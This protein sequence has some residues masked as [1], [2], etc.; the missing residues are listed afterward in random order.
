[1][2][3]A[4]VSPRYVQ[5]PSTFWIGCSDGFGGELGADELVAKTGGGARSATGDA[6]VGTDVRSDGSG[7]TGASRALS[8][9]KLASAC[10]RRASVAALLALVDGMMAYLPIMASASRS[11]WWQ[12]ASRSAKIAA[13]PWKYATLSFA[14]SFS[15]QSLVNSSATFRQCPIES[16]VRSRP[17]WANSAWQRICIDSTSRFPIQQRLI[18]FLR[19]LYHLVVHRLEGLLHFFNGAPHRSDAMK[20]RVDLVFLFYHPAVE[21]VIQQCDVVLSVARTV[22]DAM[23]DV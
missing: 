9:F 1:M 8:R 16:S 12:A 13:A 23:V 11:A 15:T 17:D 20:T 7:G 2:P 21:V 22:G 10:L 5:V 4:K 19:L 3:R 18:P 14:R 6:S